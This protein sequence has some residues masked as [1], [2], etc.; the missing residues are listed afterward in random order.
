MFSG[1]EGEDMTM[2]TGPAPWSRP[3]P[4]RRGHIRVHSHGGSPSHMP[5]KIKI[6]SPSDPD[7][8]AKPR[9]SRHSAFDDSSTANFSRREEEMPMPMPMSLPPALSR[10]TLSYNHEAVT[11]KNKLKQEAEELDMEAVMEKPRL[12]RSKSI[13]EFT[14]IGYILSW[15]PTTVSYKSKPRQVPVADEE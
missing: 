15:M 13:Q 14:D 2:V 1:R 3:V 9:I 5:L 12:R 4:L 11:R 10:S 6:K 7:R 8:A